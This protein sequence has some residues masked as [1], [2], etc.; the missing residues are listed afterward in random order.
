MLDFFKT[1]DFSV[2]ID[3]LLSIIPAMLC[4][5]FHEAS[6]AFVAY[7]LGDNTAK[8]MGRLTLNPLKHFDFFGVLMMAVFHFG[9]AK[10][11]PVDM[12]NFRN[13]KAGMALTSAAGPLSNFVLAAFALLIYG[14]LYDLSMTRFPAVGQY[15][16]RTLYLTAYLSVALGIFNLLPI[17]PLDGSKVL[18]SFF[19]N[20][21]YYKL[22][23]YERY[24]MIALVLLVVSGVL[25]RPLGIAVEWIMDKLFVI[26]ELAYKITRL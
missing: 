25:G 6:H 3:I 23:R 7:K 14:L 15:I 4:I 2:L 24:G 11:V 18:F 12:R 17:P 16:I 21:A 20:D 8:S 1:L 13:P 10:P 9:W 5:T 19:S 26:A 22:M